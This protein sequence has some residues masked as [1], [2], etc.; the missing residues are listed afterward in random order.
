LARLRLFVALDLPEG[1]KQAIGEEMARA[2]ASRGIRWASP[3]QVHLTLKFL[4]HIEE[5]KLQK[6]VDLLA[7]AARSHP[8]MRLRLQGSGAFPSPAKAR[9]LWLGISGDLHELA[10]LA[11]DIDAKMA[12]VGVDREKRRFKPHLTLARSKNPFDAESMVESWQEW[13][14]ERED[15]DFKVG[16]VRL[17]RS[18]LKPSGPEY[19]GLA[20]FNL[21]GEG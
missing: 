13:M 8:P 16:E 1:L 5:D 6:V 3:Q 10:D 18:F 4:G 17:Y 19:V 11:K 14:D 2:D 15:L 12:K 20:G 9:V 7:K 21:G